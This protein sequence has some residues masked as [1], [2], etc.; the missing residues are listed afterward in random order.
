M[1]ISSRSGGAFIKP[2]GVVVDPG[3]VEDPVDPAIFTPEVIEAP[4]EIVTVVEKTGERIRRVLNDINWPYDLSLIDDGF[5]ELVDDTVT[6]NILQYL[7]KVARLEPGVFFVTKDGRLRFRD[8]DGLYDLPSGILFADDGSGIP[9]SAL[10]VEYGTEAI[11]NSSIVTNWD[12]EQYT[13]TEESS[14]GLYGVSS[15]SLDDGLFNVDL[16]A[17]VYSKWIVGKYAFP[18]FRVRQ[19]T[20]PLSVA[21]EVQVQTVIDLEIGDVVEVKFT[22]AGV[23]SPVQ[24]LLVVDAIAHDISL[25]DHVVTFDL[26]E[27]DAVFIL[28]DDSYGILDDDILGF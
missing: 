15:F 21:S 2:G 26:S 4:V 18:K 8:R 25:V 9:F 17:E 14:I 28:D 13:A 7:Q 23:G 24:Q 6:G 1:T 20:V 27:A 10:T 22:P 5:T 3:P 11:T 12:G 16:D 19:I